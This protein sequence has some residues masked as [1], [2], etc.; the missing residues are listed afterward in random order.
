MHCKQFTL[1]VSHDHTGTAIG[2][3]QQLDHGVNKGSCLTGTGST[4]DQRVGIGHE[5]TLQFTLLIQDRTHGYTVAL[6][7]AGIIIIKLVEELIPLFIGHK[8]AVLQNAVNHSLFCFSAKKTSVKQASHMT[9]AQPEY[10]PQDQNDHSAGEP[11]RR[12]QQ[13]HRMPQERF[14]AYHR[15]KVGDYKPDYI[16][17]GQYAD[18][19]NRYIDSQELFIDVLYPIL[20]FVQHSSLPFFGKF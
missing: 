11:G 7:L 14:A 16:A 15:P 12:L 20:Q 13:I 6:C 19:H 18:C 1:G 2:R 3:A 10:S 17:N 9:A 4:N 8:A 5:I